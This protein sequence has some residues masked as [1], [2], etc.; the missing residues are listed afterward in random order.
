MDRSS[1]ILNNICVSINT[2]NN[3]FTYQKKIMIFGFC[4]KVF[5]NNLFHKSLHQI[6]VFNNAMTN[7]PLLQI[8]SHI[9]ITCN[10]LTNTNNLYNW[11]KWN[12]SQKVR[13]LKY[14][15]AMKQRQRDKLRISTL[16]YYYT[17]LPFINNIF[18]LANKIILDF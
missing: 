16:K 17:S 10:F 11:V 8:I 14:N 3:S 15:T 5:K 6:P 12:A 18:G 2:S 4:S 9:S 7:R 1:N 13:P